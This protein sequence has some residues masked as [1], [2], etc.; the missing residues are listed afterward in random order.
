[1]AV[2]FARRLRREVA[3]DPEE[4][5]R[6]ARAELRDKFLAADLGITGANFAVADTGTVVLVTNEGNGRMVTSLP[7]VHV[8][9]MGVEKVVPSM[10]DLVVFLAILAKS[11]T[12]Q[13]LSSYTT[14]VQGPRR[15]GELEGAEEFHLVLLDNGRVKQIGGTL[16]EALSCLRCGA[17]LN[18][19]PVYRQIGGHAYGYT[20]PGPIGILLTAMLHGDG[21]VKDLAHASSLC[22]ACLDACPV[23]IDIPRML[24]E[25]RSENVER[26]VAPRGERSVFGLF[27]RL[28]ARPRLYRLAV[29]LGRL[30]QRPFTTGGAIRRLPGLFGE[31]T[32]TR[33]LPPV[34][35][36]TFTERWAE[37]ERE[38]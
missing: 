16:R 31:W 6:I 17:C 35:P 9:V 25:L 38:R 5:T 30:A 34:A 13:K 22:G 37:L 2:L 3:A 36:R 7:R 33:D 28:L 23:R 14:L 19:C 12:G 29:R 18:V 21:A 15:P 10:T 11:A 26:A 4:L 8:A 20:Y 24:I 32:R 1:V 27:A